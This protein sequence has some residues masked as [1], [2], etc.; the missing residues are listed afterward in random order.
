MSCN[1]ACN[2]V[3]LTTVIVGSFRKH[4]SHI[5][6]LKKQLERHQVT[7]L[8]PIEDNVINPNADF[9]IFQ[10]DP[11]N[12]LKFLQDAVFHKIK[13]STF[14]VIANI[15]GYIGRAALL[16]MGYALA[17][18]VSIYTVEPIND[19]HFSPYCKELK[20][21]FPNIS[22]PVE[23]IGKKSLQFMANKIERQP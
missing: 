13:N 16:E 4:L 15:N 22:I 11:T 10:S 5:L 19:P 7:V 23:N 3:T 2:R 12:N 6:D 9:V 1:C 21:I 17:V 14:V 18:G 8:S 20:E